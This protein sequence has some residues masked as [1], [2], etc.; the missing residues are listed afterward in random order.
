MREEE[1]AGSVLRLEKGGV[2]CW[3][4]GWEGARGAGGEVELELGGLR[5]R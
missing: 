3:E 1:E 5:L 4:R 2:G